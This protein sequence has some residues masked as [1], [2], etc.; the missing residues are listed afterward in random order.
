VRAG[1]AGAR[2]RVVGAARAEAHR[3]LARRH[4]GDEPRDEEGETRRNSRRAN[5]S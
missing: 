5:A 1:R 2:R 3:D 4:V